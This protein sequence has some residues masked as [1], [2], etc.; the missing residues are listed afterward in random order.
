MPVVADLE[1]L[2]A[3]G[4]LTPAQA[5]ELRRRARGTMIRL[6][7]NTLLSGGI[8]IS[9]AGLVVLLADPLAVAIVG[10]ALCSGGLLALG[11]ASAVWRMFA[12]AGFLIGAGMLVGGA[13][14][15]IIDK[16]PPVAAAVVGLIAGGAMALAG[17]A[18]LQAGRK[19]FGFVAGIG[20]LTGVGLHLT[21]AFALAQLLGLSG[22]T[23]VL[24][25]GYATGVLA[26]AG[27][28][29][30]VRLVTA[31]AIVPL[32][33]MLET[34]TAYF[35]AVY[36]FY[37]PE[38]TL[39]ILQMT[40]AV[41]ACLW[42]ARGRPERFARHAGILAILAAVVANLCFLVGS[43]WGDRIGESWVRSALE[44]RHAGDWDAVWQG[45]EAFRETALFIPAGAFALVW[46]AVLAVMAAWSSRR[47]QRGLFN[48]T[49][50]FAA[51]HA[52][53]QV[54]STWGENP[55][56]WVMGGLAAIPLAWGLWRLD[57]RFS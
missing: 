15:E 24:L 28:T 56:A 41:A 17:A 18:V 3:D 50:T 55:I 14:I 25:H 19:G 23:V 46:A 49:M 35:H 54:F 9:A 31:T 39:S 6:A 8:L 1:T 7:V 5:E 30:D 57:R 29:T 44:D 10:A 20:L 21:G 53:T 12:L 2:L 34:G 13:T 27:W 32:A 51:I 38:P 11:R 45:M 52:Y 40:L 37:S 4:V 26:V 33:Q 22:V 36:V 43:L 16:L 48:A 42:V 47:G